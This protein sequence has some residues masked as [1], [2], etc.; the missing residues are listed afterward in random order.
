MKNHW[1][2]YVPEPVTGPMTHWVHRR[3]EGVSRGESLAY[4]PPLPGLVPGRG[5]ALYFVEYDGFTFRFSSLPE[6][7]ECI[8]VLGQK[9]LPRSADLSSDFEGGPNAHWLSRLAAKVL[10]W[11]YRNAVVKYLARAREAFA[12]S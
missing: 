2:E 7:D 12:G 8:D 10:T 4:D 11:K 5:Y 9:L 1:V 6:L 3:V